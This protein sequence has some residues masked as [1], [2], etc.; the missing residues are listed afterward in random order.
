MRY[1][2][3]DVLTGS[4]QEEVVLARE[5]RFEVGD[6]CKNRKKRIHQTY[7]LVDSEEEKSEMFS[8]VSYFKTLSLETD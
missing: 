7:H 6:W 3:C 4:C 5:T 2:L 1:A 8:F